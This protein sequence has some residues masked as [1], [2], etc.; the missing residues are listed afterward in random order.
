MLRLFTQDKLHEGKACLT[1]S[2]L[3][4]ECSKDLMYI[5][6]ITDWMNYE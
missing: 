3:C 4:L 2:V 6:L 1:I 5:F